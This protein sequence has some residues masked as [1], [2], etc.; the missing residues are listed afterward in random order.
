MRIDTRSSLLLAASLAFACSGGSATDDGDDD[1]VIPPNELSCPTPTDG[2]LSVCDLKLD[3]GAAQPQ[4]GDAIVVTNVVVTTPPYSILED[5]NTNETTLAGFFVQDQTSS[6]DLANRYSGIIVVYRPDNIAGTLPT[7]GDV[8]QITGSFRDF[9]QM[10][11]PRQKQIEA[12]AVDI[13]SSGA[14]VQ[15]ITVDDASAIATGGSRAEGLEGVL[16]KV[17]NVSAT[18]VR[19]VPGAGGSSIFGAFQITGGLVVSNEV[20]NYRAIEGESFT[21]ITG[22]LRVGTAPF[23]SGIYMLTPRAKED[24]ASTNPTPTISDITTIQDPSATGRPQICSRTGNQTVGRCPPVALSGVVVTASG[25]Y[26][27]ANLRS[28]WV[29]DPTVTDGRFAGVKV[30][31]PEDEMNV[32]AV[33]DILDI[34]GE[35]IEWFRGMQVQNATFTKV[36]TVTSSVAPIVVTPADIARDASPES[37]PYEGVLVR[38]ENVSVTERCVD[39]N[40][41]D[42]GNW[43]VTGPVFIGTAFTY[44]YNGGF[45]PSTAMCNMASVDCSCAGMSRPDDL[46]TVGD[47][48]RSISG[49]MNFSFDEFRLE[50]RG[51]GDIVQ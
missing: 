3:G 32:P 25:G 12:S 22:V 38:I 13:V 30:V 2:T 16:V 24:I 36:G 28:I 6:A 46:R 19:D 27:S 34:E 43:V 50:P 45:G 40:G 48:F 49:V 33:G 26:V 18:L 44:E 23:D 17:S 41:R 37:N 35:A 15:P 47:T 10:S 9:G 42:F 8:V 51:P 20:F 5:Q 11:G 29:Q 39:S 14:A 31:Y 21:S 7:I 4:L 1:T